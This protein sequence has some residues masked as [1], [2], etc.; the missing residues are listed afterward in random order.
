MVEASAVNGWLTQVDRICQDRAKKAQQL[1]VDGKK[2]IGYL[3]CF[4]PVEI[5]TAADMVPFRIVGNVEDSSATAN[6]LIEPIA[7]SFTRSCFALAMENG[8]DF[9][10]GFVVPH[11]CDNIVK[12]YD[13]WRYNVKPPYSHFINIPHTLS[14][15]SFEFFQA[16]LETFK[17][18]WKDIL[19]GKS[20]TRN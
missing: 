17:K 16:E 19:G 10:D 3:C 7:C 13:I 12:L 11:T 15:A 5:I 2:I 9:L 1:K 14:P 18:A 6:A 20:P 4:A 8:Y